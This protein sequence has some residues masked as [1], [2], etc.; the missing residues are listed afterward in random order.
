MNESEGK[1]TTIRRY[2]VLGHFVNSSFSRKVFCRLDILLASH[3]QP[4]IG[5]FCYPVI[6]S[7][8]D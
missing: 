6:L 7:N 5:S 2:L 8:A 3:F 1:K 4:V